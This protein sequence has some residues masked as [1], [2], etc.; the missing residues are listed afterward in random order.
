MWV[1]ACRAREGEAEDWGDGGGLE[2]RL[3]GEFGMR[4]GRCVGRTYS[5]Y[6]TDV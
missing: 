3:L 6:N 2:P 4:D 1:G 5:V